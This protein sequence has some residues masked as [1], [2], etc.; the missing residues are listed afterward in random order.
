MCTMYI[1]CVRSFLNYTVN[2][3]EINYR[4]VGKEL[5]IIRIKPFLN[6]FGTIVFR[7]KEFVIFILLIFF[8]TRNLF[9]L[10]VGINDSR[11]VILQYVL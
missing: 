7:I 9:L 4:T 6:E 10:K 3:N 2:W 5:W 1:F 11:K 8:L